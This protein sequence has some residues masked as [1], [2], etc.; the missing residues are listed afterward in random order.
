[1]V[2]KQVDKGT[3]ILVV[4]VTLL[5]SVATSPLLLWL[6][7]DV[8][9]QA[10]TG[11]LH[12][13]IIVGL[14]DSLLVIAGLIVWHGGLRAKDLG[15]SPDRLIP[16]LVTVGLIWLITQLFV[17]VDAQIGSSPEMSIP[18][19]RQV[20]SFLGNLVLAGFFEEIVFRGFLLV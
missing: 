14:V 5:L 17:F 1:M 2:L 12:P 11:L 9:A 3:L 20:G 19:S 7:V 18:T 10:S 16:G 8:S 13:A 15:L 6:G 4:L